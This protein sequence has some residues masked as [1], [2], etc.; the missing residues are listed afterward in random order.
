MLLCCWPEPV[1]AV[2]KRL[3]RNRSCRLVIL[4]GLVL[5][6]G[7]HWTLLQ[8]V[9]WMGMV[10]SYSQQKGLAEA[11][12]MTFDGLHP[13][14]LC[15]AVENGSDTSSKEKR[16]KTG[17]DMKKLDGMLPAGDADRIPSPPLPAEFPSNH[18]EP[19]SLAFAPPVPPPRAA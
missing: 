2:F 16:Q 18:E 15:K 12:E 14:A 8:S 11:L 9:A 10:V 1:L 19:V 7:L 17:N 3:V 5:S 13:C 6:L 4:L